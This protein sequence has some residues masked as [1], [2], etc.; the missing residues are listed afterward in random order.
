MQNKKSV[1]ALT[2]IGVIGIIG[3]TFAYFLSSTDVDN[4][5]NTADY[6]TTITEEFVSPDNWV[7]GATEE[8]RVYVTNIGEVPVAVR[9]SYTESWTSLNGDSLDLTFRKGNK[10]IAAANFEFGDDFVYN[11]VKSTENGVDYY[12]YNAILDSGEETTDF[13]KSITFNPNVP[14]TANCTETN[15][16]DEDTGELTGISS[17]CVSGDGYDGATYTLTLKIETVQSAVYKTVWNTEYNIGTEVIINNNNNNN[18][19]NAVEYLMTYA[20]NSDD[21][22]YNDETKTKMFK[23]SHEATEQT[24]ALVDYR[25]IGDSPNNYV[26][27]NCISSEYPTTCETWRIIGIFSVERLNPEDETQT[28]TEQRIKL[29]KGESFAST[30]AWDTNSQN[31]WETASLQTFLNDN[32][33]N[34]T[35]EAATYGLRES[36]RNMIDDA[37]FYLGATDTTSRT[38]EQLYTIER[39][40]TLCK[41]CGSDTTKLNW[42]GKV[43]L[44]YPSDQYLV[45]GNG[46][47]SNC[48]N[49][50]ADSS[51]CNS[52]NAKTGWLYNSNN[53]KDKTSI[54]NTWL[55]SPS[56]Y[57]TNYASYSNSNGYFYSNYVVY[58]AT[59]NAVRPVVYLKA[60]I[61]LVDGTG[62]LEEPYIFESNE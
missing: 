30:M 28:I 17:T 57:A 2:L 16:Y 32:Y 61:K 52:T 59:T 46:V 8:K 47:N 58:N 10:D 40:N 24:D 26:Y 12:Y 22:E 34:R 9:I 31:I 18:H 43:A 11:W 5:F 33:Y 48:Y 49:T 56:S 3:L 29:V 23:F 6:G 27:F 19:P 38:A 4:E 42:T 20:K 15:V 62:T 41:A 39:G 55:L 50:P 37:K 51:Y 45:Y 44:M 25:Y 36:S 7:P 35:G 21:A 53:L 14:S 54:N 1:I 60:D 13:I